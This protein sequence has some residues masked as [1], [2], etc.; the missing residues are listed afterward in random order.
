VLSGLYG[1]LR[2]LDAIRPYRLEMGTK[3]GGA[4]LATDLYAFWGSKLAAALRDDVA[5][6][7]PA[8]RCVVNCA[9]AEYFQA[10][11]ARQRASTRHCAALTRCRLVAPT[12]HS[13]TWTCLARRCT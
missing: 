3:L 4:G 5:Q 6:L 2:P 7:P 9:S 8:E 11:K 10:V 1:V 13:R 12:R